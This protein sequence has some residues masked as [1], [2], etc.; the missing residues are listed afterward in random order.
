MSTFKAYLRKEIIE[1]RRQHRYIILAVGILFFAISGPIILKLLPELLKSQMSGDIS[2]LIVTTRKASMQGLIKDLFQLGNLFVVLALCGILSDEITTQKLVFPYAKGSSPTQIVFA[3]L[4]HYGV[5]IVMLIFIGFFI[6]Y[7]YSN[8]LFV[9]DDVAFANVI[10]SATLT[11]L[12]FFFNLMLT[13]FFSSIFKKG[14]LAGISILGLNYFSAF[15][16]NI[17]GITELLPYNLVTSARLFDSSL[18]IRKTIVLTL[19]YCIALGAATVFRMNK[20]EV[21]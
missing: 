7:Y 16:S 1:S 18:D 15:F 14:I 20:V 21:I 10:F 5:V 19:F 3:K 4:L 6:N 2:G 9:G 17:K 11:A 13:M 12:Y 8:L